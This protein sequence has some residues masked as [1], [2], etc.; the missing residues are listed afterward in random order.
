MGHETLDAPSGARLAVRA[1]DTG[2]PRAVVCIQ[3]GM[4]EHS[5]RYG[6]FQNALAEAGFASVAHDHRGHGHT[7]ADDAPLGHFAAEDGWGKVMADAHFVATTARERHPAVPLFVFGHSM[8]G[9]IAMNLAL[10]HADTF[11]GLAVWNIAFRQ[12]AKGIAFRTFLRVERMR[13]GSDV[14]SAL[15]RK[16]TFDAF[17]KRFAPNRTEFDWLS[18]DTNR[19]DRYV[20]DP[21]CGFP[22]TIGLWMDVQEGMAV[23]ADD[24]VLSVLPRDMPIHLLGGAKDPVTEDGAAT[25]RLAKRLRG[26]GLSDVTSTVLDNTRHEALNEVNR[27]TTT[28]EFIEWLSKRYG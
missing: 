16:L 5:E 14:P 8:G 28:R 25:I 19:V 3:H 12:G 18:R 17:N 9:V 4:A 24:E 15:A 11:T 23:A 7:E 6:E 21:L 13:R 10:R 1:V 26:A 22:V 27:E 2:S 20:A